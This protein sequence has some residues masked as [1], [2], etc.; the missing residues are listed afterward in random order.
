MESVFDRPMPADVL[1]RDAKGNP[2]W[3]LAAYRAEWEESFEFTI[4]DPADLTGPE[5]AVWDQLP[6]I[7]AAGGGRPKRVRDVAI[8]ET[9]R[10]Q[11][12]L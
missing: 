8:S 9:M 1:L 12:D 2:M 7:F 11:P 3:D 5:R 6:A 4:I 10:L